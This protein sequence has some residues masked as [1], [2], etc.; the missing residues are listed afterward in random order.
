M[1]KWQ[2]EGFESFASWRKATEKARRD[3]K[4]ARPSLPA[5]PPPERH[6]LI[7]LDASPHLPVLA[8]TMPF[9]KNKKLSMPKA[10]KTKVHC[11]GDDSLGGSSSSVAGEMAMVP[12]APEKQAE[13]PAEAAS[14]GARLRK[15]AKREAEDAA[16]LFGCSRKR[17]RRAESEYA[18]EVRLFN[19]KEE[20]W[21]R[22]E[23]RKP[24]PSGFSQLE[25]HWKSRLVLVKA[26]RKLQTTRVVA[27]EAECDLRAAREHVQK[28]EIARLHRMLRL[29]RPR[30]LKKH[31]SR[32]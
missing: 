9:G 5:P 16:L 30:T 10:K 15:E 20:R 6:V 21:E 12:N 32:K 23:K 27:A 1:E 11:V 3:A 29:R 8:G 14:P 4:K 17:L 13:Q 22:A 28:L 31:K 2:Q 26:Q 7:S 24:P 25:K 19:L 18:V